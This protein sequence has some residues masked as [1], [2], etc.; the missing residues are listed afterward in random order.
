MGV[1]RMMKQMHHDFVVK[2]REVDAGD[3]SC[4]LGSAIGLLQ[5]L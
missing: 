4:L 5:R 2:V 3:M 1:L